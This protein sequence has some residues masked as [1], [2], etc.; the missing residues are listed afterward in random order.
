MDVFFLRSEVFVV[1]WWKNLV[2]GTRTPPITQPPVPLVSNRKD[3][4]VFSI[5]CWER[6]W[7]AKLKNS[8]LST[9]LYSFLLVCRFC[10]CHTRKTYSVDIV[11]KINNPILLWIG[12]SG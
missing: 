10:K 11:S 1:S 2:G 6:T 3:V 12:F 7:V 9:K 5:F 8:N 4:P